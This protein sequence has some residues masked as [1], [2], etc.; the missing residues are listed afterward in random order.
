MGQI[1]MSGG[2]NATTKCKVVNGD[3]PQINS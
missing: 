3:T 1:T 2:T